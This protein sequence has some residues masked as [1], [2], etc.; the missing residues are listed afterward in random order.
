MKKQSCTLLI[1]LCALTT[2]LSVHAGPIGKAGFTIT[3]P[4]KYTLIRSCVAT[5]VGDGQNGIVVTNNLTGVNEV[6][7]CSVLGGGGQTTGINS[8]GTD[9]LIVRRCVVQGCEEGFHVSLNCK[10]FD[11]ATLF[12]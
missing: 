7:D 11:N 6:T 3:K 4:G 2:A 5:H 12:C 10:L 8:G 1:A 9:G